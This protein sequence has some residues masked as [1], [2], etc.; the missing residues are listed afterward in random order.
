MKLKEPSASKKWSSVLQTTFDP[1]DYN[2]LDVGDSICKR[3]LTRQ[4]NRKRFVK[5]AG[6][7]QVKTEHKYKLK[8]GAPSKLFLKNSQ[9]PGLLDVLD[10]FDYFERKHNTQKEIKLRKLGIVALWKLSNLPKLATLEPASPKFVEKTRLLRKQ[11]TLAEA[12]ACASPKFKRLRTASTLQ[13]PQ[14]PSKSKSMLREPKLGKKRSEVLE[15]SEAKP[16]R[17]CISFHNGTGDQAKELLTKKFKILNWKTVSDCEE[18]VIVIFNECVTID[19]QL[20]KNQLTDR[21]VIGKKDSRIFSSDSN[22][23]AL[24][25]ACIDYVSEEYPD[26]DL[27]GFLGILFIIHNDVSGFYKQCKQRFHPI[28]VDR[29]GV[30]RI[31]GEGGVELKVDVFTDEVRT[32]LD[33][34]EPR[35]EQLAAEASASSRD[36]DLPVFPHVLCLSHAATEDL[37]LEDTRSGGVFGPSLLELIEAQ[38]TFAEA[39]H[40]KHL[41][42]K[43]RTVDAARSDS[44]LTLEIEIDPAMI[45]R[46]KKGID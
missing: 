22:L 15:K 11:T 43:P 4:E 20:L 44:G 24:L 10:Q 17:K 12:V 45:R 32:H 35:L 30:M 26:L 25:G 38:F 46:R 34:P 29:L 9:D 40:G 5:P 36:S 42:L 6:V 3:K 23:H 14:S 7:L 21:W 1:A 18:H 8:Q 27:L 39:V 16:R 13:D 31:S 19:L 2:R 33:R 41:R 37:N 28:R